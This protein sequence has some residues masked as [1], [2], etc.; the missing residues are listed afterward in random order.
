MT[1]SKTAW[2]VGHASSTAVQDVRVDHRRADV[3]GLRLD[4][5]QAEVV[6]HILACRTGRL[7][8]HVAVCDRCGQ[9][10]LRWPLL[11]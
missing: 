3:A 9:L 8:G 5:E 4:H 2:P 6:A 10:A 1:A 11:A 7:G